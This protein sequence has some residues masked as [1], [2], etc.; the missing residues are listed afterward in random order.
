MQR[1][2]QVYFQA[3]DNMDVFHVADVWEDGIIPTDDTFTDMDTGSIDGDP[4]WITG[5]RP[6]MKTVNVDGDTAVIHTWFKGDLS[7]IGYRLCI[8]VEYE[9]AEELLEHELEP[10]Q[11]DEEKR[12]LL[13]PQEIHL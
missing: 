3:N 12:K 13:E 11:G 9:L 1:L 5:R 10:E 2:G 6:E 7:M 4:V 8:Y